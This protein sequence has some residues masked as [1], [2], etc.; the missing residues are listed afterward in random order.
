MGNV[1]WE[2]TTAPL[3]EVTDI[4]VNGPIL[5]ITGKTE[6][7]VQ[8]EVDGNRIPV[9]ADGSFSRSI[10][11]RRT[12]RVA[13]VVTAIDASG[14]T[15]FERREVLIEADSDESWRRAHYTDP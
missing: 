1:Y 6:P 9:N 10:T 4:Y 3:L 14:N 2:D 5:I 13:V 11:H 15:S 8:L 7:G 12:G